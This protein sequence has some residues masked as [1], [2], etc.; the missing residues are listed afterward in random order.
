LILPNPYA[1]HPPRWAEFDSRARIAFEVFKSA[2]LVNRFA[3]RYRLAKAFRSIALD[4]Y[5]DATAQGYNALTR[6]MFTWSAFE[7][8]L[9]ALGMD[10]KHRIGDIAKRYNYDALLGELRAA[11]PEYRFFKFVLARLEN[12]NQSA[13]FDNFVNGKPCCGVTLARGVRHIFVHGPLTPS[14]NQAEPQPSPPCATGSCRACF[15]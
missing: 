6:L 8:L 2:A 7:G 15:A 14:A 12:K 3:A 1:N 4:G 11:D 9:I 10:P 5:S 13:E